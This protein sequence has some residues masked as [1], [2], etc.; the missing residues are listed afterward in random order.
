MS[1]MWLLAEIQ[2]PSA[3][4]Q[5]SLYQCGALHVSSTS[6]VRSGT[7]SILAWRHAAWGCGQHGALCCAMEAVGGMVIGAAE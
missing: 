2:K 5:F 1:N 7:S 6:L 4:K 3:S